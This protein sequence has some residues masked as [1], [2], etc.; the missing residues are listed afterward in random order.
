MTYSSPSKLQANTNSRVATAKLI[1]IAI[2]VAFREDLDDEMVR[3]VV[4]QVI[5]EDGRR[6]G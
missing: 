4:D 6:K 5:E 1:R 3:G 2:R